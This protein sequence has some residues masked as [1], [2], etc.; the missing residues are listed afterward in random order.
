MKQ[1]SVKT[2][3]IE[4]E[5][6]E[7]IKARPTLSINAYMGLIMAKLKGKLSGKEIIEVLKK[8]VK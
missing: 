5:V 8:Y 6:Q 3:D 1:D 2:E 7:L 4:K